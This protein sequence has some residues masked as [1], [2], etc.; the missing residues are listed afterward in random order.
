M[1][2]IL[3]LW[4]T[5]RLAAHWGRSELTCSL[6][7]VSGKRQLLSHKCFFFPFNANT[8][9]HVHIHR[10]QSLIYMYA[11]LLGYNY[12]NVNINKISLT[13]TPIRMTNATS[14]TPPMLPNMTPGEESMQSSQYTQSSYLLIYVTAYSPQAA[15]L[16]H[17]YSR[18]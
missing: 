13:S 7:S 5:S 17:F 10:T 12:M 6:T 18:N 14:R 8:D 4:F 11:L 9:V 15:P 2:L 3:H 1:A 16:V